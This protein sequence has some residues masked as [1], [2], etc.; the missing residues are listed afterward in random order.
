VRT[1]AGA[2]AT[3]RAVSWTTARLRVRGEGFFIALI[4]VAIV[5]L[6]ALLYVRQVRREERA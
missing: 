4:T 5:L 2:K 3:F 1:A 6:L